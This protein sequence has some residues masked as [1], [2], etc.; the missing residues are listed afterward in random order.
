MSKRGKRDY[1][2]WFAANPVL[3]AAASKPVEKV[4]TKRKFKAWADPARLLMGEGEIVM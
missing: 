2:A 4:M 3:A 1:K